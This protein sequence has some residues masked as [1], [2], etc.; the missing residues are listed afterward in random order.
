MPISSLIV[1]AKSGRVEA[2]AERLKT[3]PEL[4]VSP[5][6]GDQLVVVSE[7]SDRR[8][9]KDVYRRIEET[10]E[11]VALNLIYVSFEDLES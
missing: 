4:E 6:E 3:F 9:D 5:G 11:V 10:E 2:V 1:Q 8:Q 7:T